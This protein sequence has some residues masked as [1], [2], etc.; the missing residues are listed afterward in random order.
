M[1]REVRWKVA[2]CS[3]IQGP[4]VVPRGNRKEVNRS[5]LFCSS[6]DGMGGI[7]P[8]H[9]PAPFSLLSGGTISGGLQEGL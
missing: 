1:W 5:Y 2:G 3:G 7:R 4:E 8:I 9:S 6:W